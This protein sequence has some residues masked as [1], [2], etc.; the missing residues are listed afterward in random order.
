MDIKFKVYNV[1]WLGIKADELEKLYKSSAVDLTYQADMFLYTEAD[2]ECFC[3]MY[4]LFKISD[5]GYLTNP[6]FLGI[7]NKYL[8]GKARERFI[9]STEGAKWINSLFGDGINE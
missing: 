6:Y 3:K 5:D 8:I 1:D 2:T 4:V 9:K 7:D